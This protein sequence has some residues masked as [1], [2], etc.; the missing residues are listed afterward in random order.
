MEHTDTMYESHNSSNQTMR[1]SRPVARELL[2]NQWKRLTLSE[3]EAT[4]YIKPGIALLIERKYGIHRS[5]TE[6]YLS[7]LE[8]TLPVMT[9]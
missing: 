5:L 1:C 2:L 7:N 6:N 9:Q 3:L 4:H 8:R